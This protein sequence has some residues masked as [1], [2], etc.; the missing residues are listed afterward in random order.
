[1]KTLAK[2][3]TDNCE[4][5][6]EQKNEKNGKTM[7]MAEKYEKNYKNLFELLPKWKQNGIIESIKN[8]RKNDYLVIEFVREVIA[9]S[10]NEQ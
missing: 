1:M 5:R 4:T 8:N 7:K 10:E 9:V 6:I 2:E 3:K